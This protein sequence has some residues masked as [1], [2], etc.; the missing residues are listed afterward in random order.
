MSDALRRL[1]TDPIW[2]PAGDAA[3]VGFAAGAV[4]RS[5][6]PPTGLV[7]AY[8]DINGN[9]IDDTCETGDIVADPDAAAADDEA[10]DLDGDGTIS[11]SEAAQS[12]RIGG[13]NCNHGGY[14]SWVAHG[15]CEIPRPRLPSRRSSP[16]TPRR[17]RRTRPA[18]DPPH[19]MRPPTSPPRKSPPTRPSRPP[20][21]R[22]SRYHRRTA[23][24]R[25]TSRRTGMASGYRPSPSRMPSGA[26]TATTVAPSA[27]PPR[28]TT[29]PPRQL[30][31]LPRPSERQRGTPPSSRA[32]RARGSPS[33]RRPP[34]RTPPRDDGAIPQAPSFRVY[35][36]TTTHPPARPTEESVDPFLPRAY[37]TGTSQA[38]IVNGVPDT[39][40]RPDR[41]PTRGPGPSDRRSVASTARAVHRSPPPSR[42]SPRIRDASGRMIRSGWEETDGDTGRGGGG[43]RGRRRR[44][45]YLAPWA[46]RCGHPRA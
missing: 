21:R 30:V 15:S 42:A 4:G 23:I 25:W 26:R 35:A 16:V 2:V 40:N 36:L 10:V 19:A 28:R 6:A 18:P 39:C 12:D 29:K 8:V 17:T 46:A 34:T 13:V 33:T 45:R 11:V 5:S 14:V 44:G 24:R 41:G 32:S 1:T 38:P 20:T 43:R 7:A 27:R 9:G 22:V 37:A 31:T 3:I